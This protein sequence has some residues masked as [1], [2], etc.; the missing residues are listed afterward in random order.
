MKQFLYALFVL[1]LISCSKSYEEPVVDLSSYKVEKGFKLKA[2]ASEPFIEAPVTLSFD[3]KGRAWVVEMRGYMQNLEGT[4]EHMPNGRIV[5]LEDLD[6]D[7][8]CDN[9]KVFLDSLILPRAIAHVYGGLLYAEPPNLWFV[10]IENDKPVNKVLVDNKYVTGGNVEHQPNGLMMNIDNWIYNAKSSFRY[11]RK[12][13]KW[14]KERTYFR[15]QWGI[16]HDNFGRLYHNNNSVIIKGDFV[17]PNTYTKNKNFKSKAALGRNL[18][19][20]QRVYPLH[21]TSVNRGYIKGRLDKDSILVNVTASCAPLIYRGDQFPDPYQQNAFICAPEAN[22]VKRNVLTFHPN[23][24]KATHPI[25]RKEFLASTDEGFRP[26]NLFNSPEGSIYIVDMHR[27][28]LQDKAFLT[29]YLKKH[30]QDKQLDTIIGMGRI[31]KVTRSDYQPKEIIDLT[32]CRSSKLISYL[33][34]PNGWYRDKAQQLLVK[35]QDFT[36][37]QDVKDLIFKS[38]KARTQ[39]HALHTLNGYDALTFTFL[40]TL[41]NTN[42]TP[43]ETLCHA[44]VLLEQIAHKNHI[45]KAESLLKKMVAKKDIELDIYLACSLGKWINLAPDKFYPLLLQISNQHKNNQLIQEGIL[46]SIPNKEDRFLAFAK[47]YKNNS[48]LLIA[49]LNESIASKKLQSIRKNKKIKDN[50]RAAIKAGKKIFNNI[51]A[52]CH[53]NKGQGIASLAP[54]FINSEYISE[55]SERLAAIILHG[56][57][58]PLQVNG[59]SYNLSATM[60]GL[61]NNPE[62]K[63]QDIKNI[64]SYLQYTFADDSKPISVKKIKQL[65]LLKPKKG[66]FNQEEILKIK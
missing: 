45:L 65:R 62:Y 7:S 32:K 26:V 35:R 54:P 12:N 41:I 13:G 31:L 64:I 5:I 17:L 38:N 3:E 18:T 61:G 42:N 1:L 47:H 15:G 14:I 19:S 33:Q 48:P 10:E 57:S 63:D 36:V 52:T 27:G 30:Y 46:N 8:V 28:I 51:C 37:L 56:L 23:N 39:I 50:Q 24:I 20:N 59:K 60:P 55:S 66:V 4:G 34:H 9:A 44:I 49:N 43:T 6:D 29:P 21:A 11:Q 53:G 22:V 40:S 25:P 2:V 16:T 58:G